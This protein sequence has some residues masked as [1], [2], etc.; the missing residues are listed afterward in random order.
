M[1]GKIY[2]FTTKSIY[3]YIS[4]NYIKVTCVLFPLLYRLFNFYI[5]YPVYSLCYK[6]IIIWQVYI[7][8]GKFYQ[9]MNRLMVHVS[10]HSYEKLNGTISLDWPRNTGII[11]KTEYLSTFV[12]L[13]SCFKY[14]LECSCTNFFFINKHVGFQI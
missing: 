2:I 13:N 1:K 10:R 3:L 11:Y 14:I 6:I 8:Y 12:Y 4:L 7:V 9:A 5:N